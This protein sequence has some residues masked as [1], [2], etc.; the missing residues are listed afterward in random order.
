MTAWGSW[1]VY[2]TTKLERALLGD[3]SEVLSV[4]PYLTVLCFFR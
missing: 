2:I 1:C 3:N 4:S